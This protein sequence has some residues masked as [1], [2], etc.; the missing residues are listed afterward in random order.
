MIKLIRLIYTV[1]ADRRRNA[2]IVVSRHFKYSTVDMSKHVKA[3]EWGK[4][5]ASVLAWN[6]DSLLAESLADAIWEG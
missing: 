2:L 1:Q 6:P 5:A 4:V 3:G